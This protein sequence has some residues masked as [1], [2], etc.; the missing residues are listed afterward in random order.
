VGGD[1]SGAGEV[2]IQLQRPSLF[3]YSKVWVG[4]GG[5]RGLLRVASPPSP[6]PSVTQ[7]LQMVGAVQL[8]GQQHCP[9]HGGSAAQHIDTSAQQQVAALG[10]LV[11]VLLQLQVR[12][13]GCVVA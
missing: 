8:R 5:A 3:T 4:M 11:A 2:T 13:Q 9:G 6:W 7:A 10:A 1:A 12:G